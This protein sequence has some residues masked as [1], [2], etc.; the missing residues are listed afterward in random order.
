[1]GIPV[2]PA[3]IIVLYL[4]LFDKEGSSMNAVAASDFDNKQEFRGY[5]WFIL[6][7]L[8]F[9]SL[10]VLLW[11]CCNW[12]DIFLFMI[13]ITEYCSAGVRI[14]FKWVLNRLCYKYY[15]LRFPYQL[16]RYIRRNVMRHEVTQYLYIHISN[17]LRQKCH[18]CVVSWET[19]PV[20]QSKLHEESCE[21]TT[22]LSVLLK[23]HMGVCRMPR[24]WN[25]LLQQLC[26]I[27][28]ILWV[29]S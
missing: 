21:I 19:R 2:A 3:K 25:K 9:R 16:L 28:T 11:S 23:Y 22:I 13:T 24:R 6:I 1:M 29:S 15:M 12:H 14:Y 26:E 18:Y 20:W 4:W 8:G 7:T 5:G 10:L 27:L 17:L